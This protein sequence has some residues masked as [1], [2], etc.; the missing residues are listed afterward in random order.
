MIMSKKTLGQAA[1]KFYFNDI[2]TLDD[3]ML[4]E[5]QIKKAKDEKLEKEL[6]EAFIQAEKAKQEELLQKLETLELMPMGNK[7][8]IMPYVRNPYRKVISEGGIILDY[9][10]DFKNPDTGE[11]DKEVVGIGCA[12]VIEVGPEAKYLSPGD[13]IIYDTRQ[14][15]PVPFMQLGYKAMPEPNVICVIN[16]KLKE[17]WQKS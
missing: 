1:G 16:E 2:N 8:I 9:N 12:K 13:D 5:N 3:S 14:V 7:I 17:R 6:D 15:Y 11:M 10:G 4:L